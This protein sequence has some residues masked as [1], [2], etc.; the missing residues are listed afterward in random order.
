MKIVRI[1]L[2]GCLFA[3]LSPGS[4]VAQ[5]GI[6]ARLGKWWKNGRIITRLKLT[7]AQQAK[8]EALWTQNRQSLIEKKAELDKRRKE[9]SAI[10]AQNT[11]DETNAMA[12]YNKL[13]SARSDIERSTFL[14]RVRIKNILTPEQQR[15]LEAISPRVREA[16]G[17]SESD[18]STSDVPEP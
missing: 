1:A 8:I 6:G 12:A 9:L 5:N 2:I 4:S 15:R 16:L 17:N 14:M 3:L 10:I 7:P 11:L 13:L 18:S